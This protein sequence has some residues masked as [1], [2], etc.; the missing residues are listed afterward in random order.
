MACGRPVIV[1][2]GGATD[3]FC[4]ESI[5]YLVPARRVVLGARRV[6]VFD[7][8]GDPWL[9]EP[10]LPALRA[11]MRTVVRDPVAAQAKG[12]AASEHIRQNLTWA[13]TARAIEARIRD[14][15]TRPIR[16]I[17]PLAPVRTRPSVSLCMIVK[18]EAQNL[19]DCLHGLTDLFTEIVIADTGSTDRTREIAVGLGAKVVEFPWVDSFAAARNASL[20]AATGDWVLWLDADDR[21]DDANRTKLKELLGRL[22]TENAAFAMK[23]ECIADRPGAG[24]TVVDH[25]RL[26]R[27]DPRIRWRYRVHEQI[28]PA[29]RTVGGEVRWSDVVVQHIGYVDPAVRRQKL[30]RDVRLL[31]LEN[32]EHPDDPFVLFNLGS[33]FSESAR[34]ADA[35]PLLRRSLERSHPTD[36]I[37]RK[38]YALIV[39]CHRQLGQGDEALAAC[40]EGRTHY[41]DDAE[42]LFVE[43]I[44]YRERGERQSAESCWRRLLERREGNHFASVDAGLLGHKTRHNLATL[45]LEGKQEAAA[46]AQWRAALAE[47]PSYWPAW[48]GLGELHIARRQWTELEN[49]LR[50]LEASA[51][52]PSLEAAVLRARAHMERQEYESAR[53]LLAAAINQHPDE[54]LPRVILSHAFLREGRDWPAAERALRDVLR[55]APGHR[56]SRQNLEILLARHSIATNGVCS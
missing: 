54:L 5:A 34:P 42:L 32:Q 12:Q 6:D 38:L 45:Y 17:E 25:V 11:A 51:D 21:L 27:N 40:R 14:L 30:D 22:G 43:G 3:D 9:L 37:V 39:A 56:E 50:R 48:I 8:I 15:R 31:T 36:S 13:H 18:N 49:V 26:F 33:V 41:P 46:E 10:D 23:C 19:P 52:G 20:E 44:V 29:V 1:T 28:L 4:N 7:T 53:E 35:L 16:R 47:E 2:A 24:A 55:L